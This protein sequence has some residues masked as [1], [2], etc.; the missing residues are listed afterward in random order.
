MFTLKKSL[1]H[2][3]NKGALSG[4]LFA[5]LCDQLLIS[6]AN[7]R[8]YNFTTSSDITGD[9]LGVDSFSETGN[10]GNFAGVIGNIG[11]Q[12]KF[13][14]SITQKLTNTQKKEIE[15]SY[16]LFLNYNNK[17]ITNKQ[18]K[19]WILFTPED[20]HRYQLEWLFSLKKKYKSSIEL[21]HWGQKELNNLIIN[22]QEIGFKYYPELTKDLKHQSFDEYC[23]NIKNVLSSYDKLNKEFIRLKF[24]GNLQ[25]EQ[26]I[27][28]F[29][30][31]NK[32][33]SLSILGSYGTGKTT[34]LE[35]ITLKYANKYL[36]NESH[37][38]PILIKLRYVKGISSFRH[39]VLQYLFDEYGLDMNNTVFMKLLSEGKFI[40]LFDGIDEQIVE[41][42]QNNFEKLREIFDYLSPKNKLIITSRFEYFKDEIEERNILFS[43]HRPQ[44]FSIDKSNYIKS[45]DERNL[46]HYLSL[47]NS[48]QIKDYLSKK[49]GPDYNLTFSR[50]KSIYNLNE[51]SRRPVLLKMICETLPHYDKLK[52][53]ILASDLYFTYIN[54]QL[55]NDK[56]TNRI[57]ESIEKRIDIIC[58]IAEYMLLNRKYRIHHSELIQ[59]I[60]IPQS[61]S[62]RD[63]LSTSFLIR[64]T[65]GFFEFSHRS[66]L[67]FFAALWMFMS[68]KVKKKCSPL[69]N[70]PN[71]CSK[72]QLNFLMQITVSNPFVI[73]Q[74]R[75]DNDRYYLNKGNIQI[76]KKPIT[77]FSF[78]QF[79]KEVDYKPLIK[80]EKHSQ[81]VLCSWWDALAY[82]T[83][84]GGN[85]LSVEEYCG[86]VQQEWELN[87]SNYSN[88]YFD[89]YSPE[90]ASL[91]SNKGFFIARDIREWTLSFHQMDGGW[92][93]RIPSSYEYD[94]DAAVDSLA[95]FRV[96]RMKL[97][98][99][100]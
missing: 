6:E 84:I 93:D 67:E 55:S 80:I 28:D 10:G 1:F 69:W 71:R 26:I 36:R 89:G 70:M 47:W 73:P 45:S 33:Y 56:I 91:K 23:T 29:I 30:E 98:S 86:I 76:A 31:D 34:L 66:F 81:F 40:L 87:D 97:N 35:Y 14:P 62:D 2:I 99:N 63:I 25:T 60:D 50:I 19:V 5:E 88:S 96:V 9:F 74:K 78:K 3:L 21:K 83:W 79:L 22:H 49:I 13:V 46:I 82:L 52:V 41:N 8:G 90:H 65:D 68:L 37:R 17:E 53:N 64:D 24:V 27:M 85:F 32:T 59:S 92:I 48:T 43:E 72:E 57:Y 16:A 20:F 61:E 7:K 38:I 75:I 58:L 15:N 54:A 94:F 95:L 51:M 39:K 77:Y 100:K 18:I 4:Y 44:L 42:S 12:Y 11:F